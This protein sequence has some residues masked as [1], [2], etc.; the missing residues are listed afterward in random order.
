MI[1]DR[2]KKHGT[3]VV[4]VYSVLIV[5][6][7]S[8]HA[9]LIKE[10]LIGANLFKVVPT[11][12]TSLTEASEVLAEKEFDV[13]FL[14]LGLPE[15]TGLE[16]LERFL[17]SYP[18][19]PV[20]VCTSLSDHEVAAQS[21]EAGAQDYL[22]KEEISAHTLERAV[23]YAVQ[24]KRYV[25]ELERNNR[26]LEAYSR[27]VSH[28][29]KSPLR[30]IELLCNFLQDDLEGKVSKEI[31]SYL[32]DLQICSRRLLNLIGALLDFSK[33][34]E[35]ALTMQ[36]IKLEEV[37]EESLLQL[38]AS[39]QETDAKVHYENLPSVYCDRV[40]MVQV[41]Q[42]L[43]G[44]SIKYV[45]GRTPE[46]TVTATNLAHRTLIKIK[47]NGIGVEQKHLD[48]I[49]D[50][51]FRLHADVDFPGSGLG[52][53]FCKRVIDAHEGTIWMESNIGE[54]SIVFISLPDRRDSK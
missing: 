40:F 20:I 24:R 1:L 23:R 14:D 26:D 35:R 2:K 54:G 37:V 36:E 10:N 27:V 34:G 8:D 51:F 19:A 28:D 12:A 16:T 29:L 17:A 53:S 6:D 31:D 25:N 41:F 9:L 18:S 48:A 32:E 21:I 7:D 50:P 39:I 44:N 22:L 3:S 4:P 33:A 38:A 45:R 43:L 42:N 5:E 47:D 11:L 30:N 13:I 49:F 52:L 15:S 46:V